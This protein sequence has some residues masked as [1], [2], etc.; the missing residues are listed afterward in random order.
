MHRILSFSVVLLAG[1]TAF[2]DADFLERP[3]GIKVGQRLTLRPYVSLSF[4]I[5]N[6]P[7][8]SRQD[9]T[10]EYWTVNPG[11]DFD[12]DGGNW[13]INGTAFYQYHAYTSD[14]HGELDNSSYG[15]RLGYSWSNI[16][17][18]SAG[19]SLLLTEQYIRV[20]QN[21]DIKN[22]G[23]GLWRDR[24]TFDCSA[25]LQRRFNQ[26]LH[27][28]V[29]GGY[30]WLDY[31]NDRDSYAPLYGWNRWTAGLQ[32]G[33]TLSRWSDV[34]IA[35]SYQGYEQDS[36]SEVSRIG[37][38]SDC[39]TVHGGI[40]SYMT[41]RISYCVS[42]GVSSYSY[43]DAST[44]TGFTY[45]G[46]LHWK[47]GETWKTTLLFSSHYQPSE[48]E[49]GHAVRSDAVSWGI[50]K[51][52]IRN[53]LNATFDIGYRHNNTEYAHGGA[54]SW[55][56]NLITARLGVNYRINR[57]LALFARGEY[58]E[59]VNKGS[60]LGRHYDYDRLRFTIGVKFTY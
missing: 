42:G 50:A 22:S 54:N 15:E 3:N 41:E 56:L 26:Y 58:Q 1:A 28:S 57:L 46:N 9:E 47:I 18:Y 7:D 32:I 13:K 21:D 49:Y 33:S 24:Q 34:F 38:T 2:A 45:Q 37:R 52:M 29:N 40:Q 35:G 17:D 27:C 14:Y 6:N 55:D 31:A 8:T 36:G 51:S 4:T 39:W 59:E 11:I 5:D 60:N 20:D 25:V 16:E 30:Y 10:A 48:R 19:W 44:T 53:K 12:Y 23:K 43:G